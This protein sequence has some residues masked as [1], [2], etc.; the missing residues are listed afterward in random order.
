[1]PLQNI[2][3]IHTVTSNRVK[4]PIMSC[5]A[6]NFQNQSRVMIPFLTI[7]SNLRLEVHYTALAFNNIRK[8]VTLTFRVIYAYHDQSAN[9]GPKIVLQR[10]LV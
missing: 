7:Y 10:R 6:L 8:I 1:M 2:I 9:N 3:H 5:H 4:D